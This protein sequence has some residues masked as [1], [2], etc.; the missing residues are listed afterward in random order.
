MSSRE[1]ARMLKNQNAPCYKCEDRIAGCHGSCERYKEW[2]ENYTDAY[3]K[4]RAEKERFREAGD[5]LVNNALD[6]KQRW[7]RRMKK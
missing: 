7:K 1:R 4:A 3:E 5:L 6:R 2:H